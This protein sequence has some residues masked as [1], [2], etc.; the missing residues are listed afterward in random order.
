MINPGPH[1][2]STPNKYR[3][4]G[5]YISTVYHFPGWPVG[6]GSVYLISISS[7]CHGHGLGLGLGL[8][9]FKCGSVFPQTTG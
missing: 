1:Q 8:V 6:S 4:G 3:L 5:E 2:F 9:I 7:H